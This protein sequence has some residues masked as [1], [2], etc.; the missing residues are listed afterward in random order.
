MVILDPFRL[1]N[2]G[3]DDYDGRGLG[4]CNYYHFFGAWAGKQLAL[5]FGK[6][7][8]G[9]FDVRDRA[10]GAGHQALSNCIRDNT[11]K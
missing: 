5:P 4:L 10:T 11:R 2:F 7:L 1:L 8:L 9:A 6:W 3:F